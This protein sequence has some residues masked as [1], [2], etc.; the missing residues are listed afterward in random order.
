MGAPVGAARWAIHYTDDCAVDLRVRLAER[1][2][3]DQAARLTGFAECP[4]SET[5]EGQCLW[6]SRFMNATFEQRSGTFLVRL[7][8]EARICP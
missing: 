8:G 4:C 7:S 1:L 2:S 6:P 3:C 5:A